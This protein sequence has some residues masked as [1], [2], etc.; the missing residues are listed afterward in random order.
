MSKNIEHLDERIAGVLKAGSAASTIHLTLQGKGGVGKSLVA[1]IL[2]Q[3]FRHHC[4]E[5]HCIDSDPVNQTFSQYTELSAEHL[6]L[7][8]DGRIDSGGFDILLDRLLNEKGTFIVDNGA[9]TFVPLWSYIVESNALEMLSVAGRKL[10]VHT[11]HNGR[12][13]AR[14]EAS[15]IPHSRS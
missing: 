6:P 9:S 15:R 1:S 5:I 12:P 11:I 13:G 3:Y 4:K 7:M 8:R 14:L 10:Y 2:A